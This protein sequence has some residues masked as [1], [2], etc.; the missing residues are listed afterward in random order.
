MLSSAFQ[1]FS[2]D[3]AAGPVCPSYPQDCPSLAALGELVQT[4]KGHLTAFVVSV[5]GCFQLQEAEKPT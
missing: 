2:L 1:V 5:P 3:L 4:I